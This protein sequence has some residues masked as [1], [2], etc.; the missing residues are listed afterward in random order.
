MKS[1]LNKIIFINSKFCCI[2][3]INFYIRD[4]IYEICTNYI[5][6]VKI[7]FSSKNL[8]Y[9][10]YSK[11][12]FIE[13]E[14]QK[15]QEII[16]KWL[17]ACKE[18]KFTVNKGKIPKNKKKWMLISVLFLTSF[19]ISGLSKVTANPTPTPYVFVKD[20]LTITGAELQVKNVTVELNCYSDH[21]EGVGIYLIENI[22]N[23]SVSF[24]IGFH[25]WDWNFEIKKSLLNNS[26]LN[27]SD[28]FP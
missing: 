8:P 4:E 16:S 21:I 7:N 25:L 1:I 17:S 2:I 5:I 13:L 28:I 14:M 11:N 18:T 19:L 6:T 22:A 15:Y 23:K 20:P 24:T 9:Y 27:F 26:E 3:I 10:L 12:E